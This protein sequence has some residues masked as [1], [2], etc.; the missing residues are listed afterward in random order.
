MRT[1]GG[2]VS[3][4]PAVAHQL[5]DV[6]RTTPLRTRTTMPPTA[7]S[8]RCAFCRPGETYAHRQQPGRATRDL[9]SLRAA[10]QPVKPAAERADVDPISRDAKAGFGK[11]LRR[12]VLQSFLR[13]PLITAA[14]TP[15]A[16]QPNRFSRYPSPATANPTS[17]IP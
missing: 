12:H 4:G 8:M 9:A 1:L 5:R 3:M 11:P 17:D 14:S 2:N 7:T 10:A 15:P 16:S 6:R 13:R